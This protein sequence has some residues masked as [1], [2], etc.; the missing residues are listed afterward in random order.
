MQLREAKKLIREGESDAVEFK[1]KLKYPEKVVKEVVA[2]ANTSGGYLFVGVND[3]GEILG[4]KYPEDEMYA[5]NKAIQQ[6]CRPALSYEVSTIPLT[7]KKSLIVYYIPSSDR[8]PHAIKMEGHKQVFV[9][10]ADKSIK[11]SK[12]VK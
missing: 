6:Y 9:R 2:F 1:R 8:K 12:Q 10:S 11:A 5:L 4:V 7:E 3:E